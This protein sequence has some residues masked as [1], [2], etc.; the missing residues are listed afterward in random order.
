MISKELDKKL[1][2]ICGLCKHDIYDKTCLYNKI[3]DKK[4]PGLEEYKIIKSL[5]EK[6]V[7]TKLDD[8]KNMVRKKVI[9][10]RK[11]AK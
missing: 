6:E 9:K 8:Y 2:C 5:I 3:L 1:I 10:K 4:E 11:N 7:Q